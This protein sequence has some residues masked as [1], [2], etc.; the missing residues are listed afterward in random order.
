MN[1]PSCGGFMRRITDPLSLYLMALRE[2][3]VAY[4]CGHQGYHTRNPKKHFG[5]PE[6]A[7]PNI[8]RL[9]DPTFKIVVAA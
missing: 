1:C 7:V 3:E 9:D 6:G 5:T 8:C 2:D 4:A